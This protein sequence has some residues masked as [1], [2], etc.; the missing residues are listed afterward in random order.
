MTV[1]YHQHTLLVRRFL[2]CFAMVL[3]LFVAFST[4]LFFAAPLQ[5]QAGVNQTIN[6]QGRLLSKSGGSVPDGYYN[7]QFKIYQDG[8]G[9]AV[10]N[11]G[12]TLKWTESYTNNNN[13][14]GVLVRNSM[15]SVNLGSSTPFGSSVDWN[16]GTLWLSLNVAGSAANCSSFAGCGAD[17]EMLPMKRITAS[18]YALNAGAVGG[19][20]A[21]NF[22]QLAQG[23][24]TDASTNTSSIFINKTGTGN[25]VQLQNAGSNVFGVTNT[26][27]IEFGN[28]GTRAIYVGNAANNVDGNNLVVHAGYGGAGN[29]NMG[30]GLFLQGGAAG[31]DNAEGGS[32]AITGGVGTGSGKDGSVY[33]GASDTD[34][35][36]IGNTGSTSSTQAIIIGH[37]SGTDSRT[38]VTIGNGAD[39][40]AGTTTVQAKDSVTINTNGVSRAT[41]GNDKTT[42]SGNVAVQSTGLD[43]T[44]TFQVQNTAGEKVFTVNAADK[45]VSIGSVSIGAGS[46]SETKSLWGNEP[47]VTTAYKEEGQQLNLGMTFKSDV[48]GYVTGVRYYNPAGGNASGTD[49]GKLWACN[50]ANCVLAEGGTELAAVNFPA[51]ASA[52]WKTAAFSTPVFINADTY[53]IV[54]YLSQSGDYNATSNYF[55]ADRNNAPLHAMRSA[56]TQNGSFTTFGALFPTNTFNSTNYWVDVTFSENVATDKISTD[57]NLLVTSSGAVAIGSTSNNLKLQGNSI[58]IAT[59]NGGN[60]KIGTNA[61]GAQTTLLTLDKSASTPNAPDTQALLGSMYYDTTLGKVQC[62][63]AEGWGSCG[64]SPDTF[65][66]LSPEYSNSVTNGSGAGTMNS[67]FCSDTLNVNDGSSA[68][69]TVCGTNEMYNFYRWTS[70]AATPQ[71]KSI[72]VTYQLPS[73]F[74]SFV[75]DSI[76]LLG[77]TDG[78]NALVSYEVLINDATGAHQCTQTIPAST[79]AQTAWQKVSTANYINADV[80][81]PKAG[82]TL[83]FKI[84]MTASADANAYASNLNFAFSTKN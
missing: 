20:T 82:D 74:N 24:Q 37:S 45:S 29:G 62:F 21:E 36:I 55:V 63:E 5:A 70:A 3:I 32:V 6:F 33:I 16:Q 46:T 57:K 71:T 41:F 30:G 77:R 15:F 80:C 1:W 59:N 11:P 12:G 23:V 43:T 17:G 51:D 79:G 31:G 18:P 34:A 10:G 66:S 44:E 56:V 81:T 75:S 47:V 42:L 69:P 72:F 68:Q 7:I 52:G 26:G 49:I 64:A 4:T 22:I 53:Y 61:G 19:K 67:D 25:L 9:N 50:S 54:T 48:S 83:L 60:V 35:V 27:D 65:V 14:E 84:N 2:S 8:L 58:N 13:N 76:S 38:N 40:T 28:G 39:A 78:T 73:N